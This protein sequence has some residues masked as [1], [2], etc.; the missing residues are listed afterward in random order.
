[1]YVGRIM[2][3]IS[4][5][6]PMALLLIML[7]R[8]IERH[9]R[10]DW[11]RIVVMVAACFGTMLTT[12]AVTITNHLPG[13]VGCALAATA[14]FPILQAPRTRPASRWWFLLAG[15]GAG[16]LVANELPALLDEAFSISEEIAQY[17]E[18]EQE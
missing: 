13:A 4:N 3:V 10:T 18:E 5:V 14:L 7:A 9:G 15:L 2:L 12:I 6:I 16:F 8:L 1:M 17:E 11:G